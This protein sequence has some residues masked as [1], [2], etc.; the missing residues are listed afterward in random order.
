M[1]IGVY[2]YGIFVQGT[3]WI[4]TVE[5]YVHVGRV[6]MCIW[7]WYFNFKEGSPPGIIQFTELLSNQLF[8]GYLPKKMC[9]FSQ[10][11]WSICLWSNKCL[12]TSLKMKNISLSSC[13]SLSEGR[14]LV[15]SVPAKPL[16]EAQLW[17]SPV[18][19]KVFRFLDLLEW[20]C[21]AELLP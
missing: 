7:T 18:S 20:L 13:H 21:G 2:W 12:D 15:H 16:A 3:L 19:E 14:K 9:Y 6:H 1:N 5:F 17:L 11:L 4:H 8:W 10:W